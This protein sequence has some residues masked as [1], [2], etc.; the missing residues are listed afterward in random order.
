[1][2]RPSGGSHRTSPGV[3][4]PCLLALGPVFLGNASRPKGIRG[5]A[6]CCCFLRNAAS[7]ASSSAP[8]SCGPAAFEIITQRMWASAMAAHQCSGPVPLGHRP[9]KR[10]VSA[11]SAVS[12]QMPQGRRPAAG[13]LLHPPRC[14]KAVKK[15]AHLGPG[16]PCVAVGEGDAAFLRR[17]HSVPIKK[18]CE[19]G[20]KPQ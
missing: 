19:K 20:P 13:V 4:G 15:A 17:R 1:M 5:H 9:I 10:W 6:V 12:V 2:L 16:P 7:S 11:R 3:R 14:G 18:P 8:A